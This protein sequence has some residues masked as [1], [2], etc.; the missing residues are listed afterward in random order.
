M[1]ERGKLLKYRLFIIVLCLVSLFSEVINLCVST[2]CTWSHGN[3]Y[4]EW[5]CIVEFD[6]PIRM[7]ESSTDG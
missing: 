6:V 3:F 7:S 1:I 2:E 5:M 4:C